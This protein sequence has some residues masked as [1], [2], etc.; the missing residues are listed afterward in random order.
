MIL[1]GVLP[2][3][4]HAVSD[5]YCLGTD[6]KCDRGSKSETPD[7]EALAGPNT[8]EDSLLGFTLNPSAVP[9]RD[10]LGLAAIYY[11]VR[12]QFLFVK[13]SGRVGAAI[14]PSNG[15]DT[16]F[17][18]PA[19]ETEVD[20]LYRR[21]EELPFEQLKVALGLAASLYDND[22]K[23]FSRFSITLGALGRYI[24]ESK[25]VKPGAGA[26]IA[27]GPLTIGGAF[28]QDETRT[29]TRGTQ[30]SKMLDSATTSLTAGLTLGSLMLDYTKLT[31][32]PSTGAETTV[33]LASLNLVL[34]RLVISGAYRVER[35]D[36]KGYDSKTRALIEKPLKE[37]IFG[38]VQYSVFS[39]LQVGAFYNY[40]LL[41]EVSGGAT[42]F[43]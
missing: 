5:P 30:E 11:K 35:S 38:G 10:A 39:F 16:F 19:L 26:T 14:S 13:G 17:G 36:R 2:A 7:A 29:G 31:A 15:D 1:F 25:Q 27:L 3:T 6:H 21:Q 23:G 42:I 33:D 22:E 24:G 18:N 32:K 37:E 8:S 4:V 40:F 43:F 9:V 12:P 34:R 41:N 20:Y 28:S